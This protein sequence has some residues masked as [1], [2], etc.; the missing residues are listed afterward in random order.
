MVSLLFGPSIQSSSTPVYL[1]GTRTRP[2]S[3][4]NARPRRSANR[5]SDAMSLCLTAYSAEVVGTRYDTIDGD[6]DGRS[7]LRPFIRTAPREC[8]N[9]HILLPI[10]ELVRGHSGYRSLTRRMNRSFVTTCRS[11]SSAA[12]ACSDV[13]APAADASANSDG[14]GNNVPSSWLPFD[15]GTSIEIRT[16]APSTSATCRNRSSE[17]LYVSSCSMFRIVEGER[18]SC[19]ATSSRRKPRSFL[20]RSRSLPIQTGV[21]IRVASLL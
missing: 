11:S 5:S 1:T 12:S 20:S 8:A 13:A 7:C 4:L 21:L 9:C 10:C 16:V 3:S 6:N 19:A 15:V 14:S 17:T 2:L 18:E